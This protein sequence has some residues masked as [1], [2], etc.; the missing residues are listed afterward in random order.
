[1]FNISMIRKQKSRCLF[2]KTLNKI[3]RSHK[4]TLNLLQMKF[5]IWKKYHLKCTQ[6]I[7]KTEFK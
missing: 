3:N 6:Y 1:M 5:S 4:F 2:K 7:V